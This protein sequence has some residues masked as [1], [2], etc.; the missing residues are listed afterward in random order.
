MTKKNNTH[1]GDIAINTRTSWR[2]VLRPIGRLLIAAQLALVLQ[3]LSVL[4]QEKGATPYNPIAQ[5]QIQRLGALNQ[6]IE[7]AKALKAKEQ[8]A[9]E[10]REPI[11]IGLERRLGKPPT[12]LRVIDGGIHGHVAPAEVR[13]AIAIPEAILEFSGLPFVEIGGGNPGQSFGERGEPLGI[14]RRPISGLSEG[15][16]GGA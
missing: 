13:D 6:T 14:G 4:A 7:Q 9:V 5:A 3:P 12:K 8:L 2:L 10:R 16:Y 15:G 11:G 1:T